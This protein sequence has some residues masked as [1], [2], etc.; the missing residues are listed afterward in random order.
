MP[1]PSSISFTGNNDI[2]KNI[3]GIFK[4]LGIRPLVGITNKP[5]SKVDHNSI[6]H[7]KICFQKVPCWDDHPSHWNHGYAIFFEK[8]AA[9]WN[10]HPLDYVTD[11]HRFHK[12][13]IQS[14]II[15]GKK[16]YS[17]KSE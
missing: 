6:M 5:V 13:S 12:D 4:E 17:A 16:P 8:L 7:R 11:E 3:N 2:V 15:D 14:K 10:F 9:Y 1:T